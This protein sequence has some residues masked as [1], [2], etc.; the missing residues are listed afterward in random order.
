MDRETE[1][2]TRFLHAPENPKSLGNNFVLCIYEDNSGRLWIGTENGLSYYQPET[3]TFKNLEHDL[4]IRIMMIQE[5]SQGRFWIA[6]A[7]TGLHLLD[8]ESGQVVE[9]SHAGAGTLE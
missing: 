4:L 5:D 2:F 6:S 9:S 1:T 3:E 8:K 7:S